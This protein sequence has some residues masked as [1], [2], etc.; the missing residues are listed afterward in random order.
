MRILKLAL[1]VNSMDR[2]MVAAQGLVARLRVVDVGT[3]LRLS[4]ALSLC[5]LSLALQCLSSICRTYGSE[6]CQFSGVLDGVL[7]IG[8]HPFVE[9]IALILDI[10]HQVERQ[11]KFRSKMTKYGRSDIWLGY[12]ECCRLLLCQPDVVSGSHVSLAASQN[13]RGIDLSMHMHCRG[14]AAIR[15]AFNSSISSIVSSGFG[16]LPGPGFRAKNPQLEA[17]RCYDA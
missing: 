3:V 10:P 1:E 11:K 17:H 2:A 16:C 12:D 6:I 9:N 8:N 13:H 5:Q 15:N 14:I 4:R 7:S